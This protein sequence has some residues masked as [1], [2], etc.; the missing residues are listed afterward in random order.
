MK[1]LIGFLLLQ[2]II[3]MINENGFNVFLFFLPTIL[4]VIGGLIFVAWYYDHHNKKK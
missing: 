1:L 4:Y 2:V 3:M